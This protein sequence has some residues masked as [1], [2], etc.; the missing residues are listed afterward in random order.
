MP[1]LCTCGQLAEATEELA[2]QRSFLAATRADLDT[3]LLNLRDLLDGAVNPN[4]V[5]DLL[6]RRLAW[7]LQAA[8]TRHNERAAGADHA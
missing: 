5:R 7:Q 2:R 6:R 3:A 8:E 1:D 4:A